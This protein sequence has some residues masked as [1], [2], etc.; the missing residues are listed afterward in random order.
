MKDARLCVAQRNKVVVV[1]MME[2]MI[3][4]DGRGCDKEMVEAAVESGQ[5]E[6]RCR[7]MVVIAVAVVNID[8]GIRNLYCAE[9]ITSSR[10]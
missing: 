9:Y 8:T 3:T 1:I 7:R 4:V 10:R 6:P 2:M 5:G